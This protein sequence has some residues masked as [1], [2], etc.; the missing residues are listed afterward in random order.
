MASNIL[1][2]SIGGK[3]Y[4]NYYTDAMAIGAFSA[5]AKGI[6]VSG[7]AGNGGPAMGSLSHN[8]PWITTVGAGTLDCDFPASVSLGNRKK[9]IEVYQSMPDHHYLVDYF[10]L[11][12]LVMQV[13]P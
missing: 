10:H 5:V 7:S 8:V 2:L 13:T 6:F 11:F 4:H 3:R 9:N 12:M 1:S